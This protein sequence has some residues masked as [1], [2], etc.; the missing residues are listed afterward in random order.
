MLAACSGGQQQ[1]AQT[2]A[3]DPSAYSIPT[4][5]TTSTNLPTNLFDTTTTSDPAAAST[6]TNYG[7]ITQTQNL[8]L[9]SDNYL[10]GGTALNSGCYANQSYVTQNQLWSAGLTMYNSLDQALAYAKSL[11]P[12]TSDPAEARQRDR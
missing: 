6:T 5:N 10:F 12:Q 1:N 7:P 4:Y 3:Y 8:C 11:Q 2:A 9:S